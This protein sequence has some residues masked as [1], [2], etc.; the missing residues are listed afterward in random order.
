MTTPL[1]DRVRAQKSVKERR[2]APKSGGHG[3]VPE[4]ERLFLARV[5]RQVQ[6]L[7]V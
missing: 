5:K 4:R 6:C 3:L 7:N 2:E 1:I